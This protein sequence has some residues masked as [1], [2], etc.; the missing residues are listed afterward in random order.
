LR[1]TPKD[2]KKI[3][4]KNKNN[5]IYS[6]MN[7]VKVCTK[8]DKELS[9]SM[10]HKD[11]RKPNG[12]RS[13]CKECVCKYSKEYAI[14]NKENRKEY[15]KEYR[16]RPETKKLEKKYEQRPEIKNKRK[17]YRNIPEI[18]Q[19]YTEYF[20]RPEV[21]ERKKLLEKQRRSII[22][23]RLKQRYNSD[24][25]YKLV[26]L[27][28]SRMYKLITRNKTKHS[29]EYLGCDLSFLKNWIEYRFN[30][31]MTWDNFGTYWHIDHILPVSKFDF[32]DENNLHICF[33][34]TN[35][36]PL[37]IE[38][39]LEKTNR[40]EH[41]HYFNNFISVFRF[42]KLNNQFLGYEALNK[43]LKWL[44]LELRYRNNPPYEENIKI[45]SEMDN[46]Q[47]SL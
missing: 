14:N 20:N 23:E 5:K 27:I 6:S 47:P 1:E 36:Q 34:W 3:D 24:V 35:L 31:T 8:C 12:I 43:S 32:N 7:N 18:K 2:V 44:R 21:I 41:H 46:P 28:R 37:I 15:K 29:V 10:F 30:E 13:D 26:C 38:E 22:N 25:N 40:I 45:F 19:R 4:L 16:S 39:N 17:E 33:H 9:F 42:N 11:K